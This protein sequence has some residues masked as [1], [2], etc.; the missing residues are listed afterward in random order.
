ML[1]TLEV[2]TNKTAV[3]SEIPELR[4]RSAKCYNAL[5][6]WTGQNLGCIR[7]YSKILASHDTTA[8]LV[9]DSCA[10]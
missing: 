9:K 7:N 8:L 2:S 6:V 10:C 1:N 3:W 5:D 4:R